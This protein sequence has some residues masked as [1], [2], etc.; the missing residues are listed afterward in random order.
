MISENLK[1]II[2]NSIKDNKLSHCYLLNCQQ[3][4][5]VDDSL[6][7]MINKILQKD[8]KDLHQDTLPHNVKIFENKDNEK[9]LNKEKIIETFENSSVTSF[10]INE[11]K[12]IIFKNIENAS[13]QALNSLLKTIE[14]P[15]NNVCFILTTSN[16]NK[17][18]ETIKS[19]SIIIRVEVQSQS[20]IEKELLNQKYSENEAWW[21]SHIFS[22]INLIK[23]TVDENSISL[24]NSLIDNVNESFSNPFYLYTFLSK[25]TKKDMKNEFLILIKSLQFI[26][27]WNWK[28]IKINN[29]KYKKIY[30][31]MKKNKFNVYACFKDIEIFLQKIKT[32]ANYFL[33]IEKLLIKIVENYE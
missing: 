1:K 10:L 14:E 19:R 25:Y 16:I 12:I 27:S 18:L 15:S 29:D 26:Y 2:S 9:N 23:N 5:N 24:I 28:H 30:Q 22:D 6:I 8:L 3:N 7:Y 33:Q 20:E 13:I 32:N 31:K 11:P 21:Y 17:I 4:K